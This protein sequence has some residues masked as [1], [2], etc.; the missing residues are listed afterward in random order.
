MT[1]LGRTTNK[2]LV[3][4]Q[5]KTRTMHSYVELLVLL[6]LEVQKGGG[7]KPTPSELEETVNVQLL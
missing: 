6:F 3:T 5:E 1:S 7:G 2:K 4:L